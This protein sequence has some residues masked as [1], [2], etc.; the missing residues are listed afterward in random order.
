MN[1]FDGP[2]HIDLAP[3]ASDYLV[4]SVLSSLTVLACFWADPTLATA[5]VPLLVALL[6]V[7]WTRLREPRW[8]ALR[9]RADGG[10]QALSIDGRWESVDVQSNFRSAVVV[11]LTISCHLDR[12]PQALWR[13]HQPH[14]FRRMLG[15]ID[16]GREA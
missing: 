4:L 13:H 2:L 1:K 11:L 6:L 10:W 9:R 14:E 15:R 16:E 8:R 3:Q 7:C 5:L 12:Q